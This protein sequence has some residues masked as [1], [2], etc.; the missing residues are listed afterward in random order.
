MV[1]NSNNIGM[2]ST[3]TTH[4]ISELHALFNLCYIKLFYYRTVLRAVDQETS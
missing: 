2:K 1:R 3:Q 4:G